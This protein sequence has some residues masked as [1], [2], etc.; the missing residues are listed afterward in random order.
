MRFLKHLLTLGMARFPDMDNSAKRQKIT[1][2]EV[3][4]M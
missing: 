3:D 4:Q 1:E 2:N